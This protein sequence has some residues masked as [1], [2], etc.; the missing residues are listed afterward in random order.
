MVSAL[1]DV[2]S[3]QTTLAIVLRRLGTRFSSKAK[4][5][6]FF[7]LLLALFASVPLNFA[8]TAALLEYGSRLGEGPLA[9]HLALCSLRQ[10]DPG[11]RV[12]WGSGDFLGQHR[13]SQISNRILTLMKYDIGR[14]EPNLDPFILAARVHEKISIPIT[15]LEGL[16][17]RQRGNLAFDPWQSA[18]KKAFALDHMFQDAAFLGLTHEFHARSCVD[19]EEWSRVA[20]DIASS[21][22]TVCMIFHG[23]HLSICRFMWG[24]EAKWQFLGSK[25]GPNGMSAKTDPRGLLFAAFKEVQKG[26]PLLVAPDGNYGNCSEE[27]RVL[28]ATVLGGEGAAFIA[29]HARARLVWLQFVFNDD[30]LVPII[31]DGPTPKKNETYRSFKDRCNA[32]YGSCIEDVLTG[33]PENIVLRSHWMQVLTDTFQPR[34]EPTAS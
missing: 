34:K 16:F 12:M 9:E 24:C 15:I 3:D 22:R 29:F 7:E 2:W 1:A 10:Q 14:I 26:V 8:L 23:G 32:F 18:V 30:V 27:L 25:A 19:M 20:T 31:I 33:A 17:D 21:H 6:D 28:G 4:E 11:K 13:V 5:E